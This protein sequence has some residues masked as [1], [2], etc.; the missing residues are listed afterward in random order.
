MP[1]HINLIGGSEFEISTEPVE[2]RISRLF[3]DEEDWGLA[4][5][6]VLNTVQVQ[7]GRTEAVRLQHHVHLPV[8]EAERAVVILQD[9]LRQARR[10]IEI[11]N[12]DD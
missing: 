12:R 5:R 2:V 10:R 7:R 1:S 3:I 9:T 6:L 4:I 8:E 11:L